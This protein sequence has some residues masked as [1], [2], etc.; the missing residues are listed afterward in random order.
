MFDRTIEIAK[1]FVRSQPQFN[2]LLPVFLWRYRVL[3]VTPETQIVIEGFPR[4]ANTFSVVAFLQSQK[5]RPKVAHHLHSL[6][7]VRRGIQ[8]GIPCLVLIRDPKDAVLSLVI[9][10][11]LRRVDLSIEEFINFYGGIQRVRDSVVIADFKDVVS[12]FGK[13]I[14]RVNERFNV[15]FGRFEHTQENVDACYEEIDRIEREKSNTGGV[16]PTHVARPSEERA[17]LKSDLEGQL[18]V[19]RAGA[20]LAEA[21]DIYRDLTGTPGNPAQEAARR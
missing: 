2:A 6:G 4:C 7:Q 9:R 13:V 15:S 14:D 12:D 8:L 19:G 3:A 17:Q 21:T 5:E 20:L 18:Q 11:N 16:R 10:K 1:R